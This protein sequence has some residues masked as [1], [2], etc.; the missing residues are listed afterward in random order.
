MTTSKEVG[1]WRCYFVVSKHTDFWPITFGIGVDFPRLLKVVWT[2]RI[3]TWKSV[4]RYTRQNPPKHN[5][6]KNRKP[7]W[8]FCSNTLTKAEKQNFPHHSHHQPTAYIFLSLLLPFIII[9][10]EWPYHQYWLRYV[11]SPILH[12]GY[13]ILS[14]MAIFSCSPTLASRHHARTENAY[15]LASTSIHMTCSGVYESEEHPLFT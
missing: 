2:P 5:I 8:D 14:D 15:I 7:P 9:L 10:G 6:P 4:W 13:C 1:Q 3:S 11:H 12:S